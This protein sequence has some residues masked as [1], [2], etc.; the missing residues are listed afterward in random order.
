MCNASFHAPLHIVKEKFTHRAFWR[1][2]LRP[3]RN[4]EAEFRRRLV[5]LT[6][7][8]NVEALARLEDVNLDPS[9]IYRWCAGK[10]GR[11]PGVFGLARFAHAAGTTVGGLLGET[12]APLS[13]EDRAWMAEVADRLRAIAGDL[14]HSDGRG[15]PS[16]VTPTPRELKLPELR[17]LE[18]ETEITGGKDQVG[19]VPQHPPAIRR[20]VR[21]RGKRT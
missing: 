17:K 6:Q 20:K 1:L 21:R 2:R 12:L 5:A 10:T 15:T 8:I 16:S 19:G 18:A 7:R 14:T 3:M 9:T 4:A 11:E 13:P